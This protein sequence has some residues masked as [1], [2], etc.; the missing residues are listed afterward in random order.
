[1]VAVTEFKVK[2]PTVSVSP[3]CLR[4]AKVARLKQQYFDTHK[5]TK[6]IKLFGMELSVEHI[7]EMC[8]VI[9]Q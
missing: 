7:R 9:R 3:K 2:A 8:R 4:P 1:M 5:E 6:I